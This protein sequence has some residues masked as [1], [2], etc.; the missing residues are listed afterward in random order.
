MLVHTR[1]HVV[2][3]PDGTGGHGRDKQEEV[4]KSVKVCARLGINERRGVV[5]AKFCI[6]IPSKAVRDEQARS[7][8]V[9]TKNA[10]F[11]PSKLTLVHTLIH[12]GA[13]PN[14]CWC[15]PEFMWLHTQTGQAGMAETNRLEKVSKYV[16]DLG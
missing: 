2:A 5:S 4:R 9:L 12:V 16:R 6:Q 10:G 13:Y 3:C 7:S 11:P 14:S 8:V 1:I 15:I